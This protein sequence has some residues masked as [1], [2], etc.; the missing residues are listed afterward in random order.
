MKRVL[1]SA[2]LSAVAFGAHAVSINEIRIDQPSTDKNEYIELV[3][4]P[5][6]SLSGL[7]YLVIGDSKDNKDKGGIIEAVVDLN[8]QLLDENGLLLVAESTF[9]PND[10]V[11]YTTELEFENGDSVTHLLVRDFTGQ[12]GLDIDTNNDG[13]IDTP[14]WSSIV[15]SVALKAPESKDKSITYGNVSVGPDRQYVPG[16]VF[17]CNNQWKIGQFAPFGATDTA[18]AANTCTPSNGDNTPLSVSIPQI[19]SEATT[20]PYAGKWV[21]TRG[22]VVANFQ[23][24]NQLKGYFL[25]DLNGDNNPK[26]SDGLFVFAPNGTSVSVGDELEITAKVKEYKGQTQLSSVRKVT[27]I[28]QSN[29]IL[30]VPLTLPETTEGE[31]ERYEGMLVTINEPMTIA[32]NYFLGRYGQMTLASKNDNGELTRIVQPTDAFAANTPEARKLADEN[33][34]RTLILDDGQD[35]NSRG[36]NPSPVP[37]LGLPANVIRGGDQVSNLVGV[38]DFG[39]VDSAPNGKE[40]RDYRLHPTKTPVFTPVN[41]RTQPDAVNG[42]LKIASF[43]VLNYFTTIDNRQPICGPKKD[44][45]CR[46]AD[47]DTELVRQQT[48]IV[49][50]LSAINADVIGLIEIENN[51]ADGALQNLVDALNAEM[52]S[53]TYAG[54]APASNTLGSD[55]ITVALIYKP[56][57]VTPVNAAQTLATGAFD[58]NLESGQSR[59]PLA[60]SFKENATGEVFTAVVNH[61]KSKRPPRSPLNNGNDDQGDGQGS[62]NLRRTEAANEL[63]AWL[64]TKPTGVDDADVIILGDLNAYANEDPIL[65]LKNKGYTDLGKQFDN[66]AYSYTFGGAVGTLDYAL[67]SQTLTP[68]IAGTSIWHINTDEPAVLD[69]D[70]RYNPAGYYSP[71]A[72][73]ASDHDP[74]IVGLNLSSAKPN[75]LD[76]D[77]VENLDDFCPNTVLGAAVNQAGCSDAQIEDNIKTYTQLWPTWLQNMARTFA[78]YGLLFE[79]FIDFSQAQTLL[80]QK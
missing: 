56:S 18:G 10:K 69:Y 62:W 77:G 25:Q 16:H 72:F 31:L 42:R 11:G 7:S 79:G 14:Y 5:N 78:I 58:P 22:V 26:T 2:S 37:Y 59:Q 73:R 53:N 68:Q 60:Q 1:L 4:S 44:Q 38:I 35:V 40:K 34:R 6:E 51:G 8:Q 19:Q 67:S 29:T 17:R 70:E 13:V 21:K 24:N 63:S 66:K 43:N 28:S 3:G 65:A 45:G 23:A 15:D 80:N 30:P 12:K 61:L 41:L 71:D 9:Q 50:A 39:R 32:Q 20:S 64:D 57:V 76:A 55:V 75:D 36:D 47:S 27:V 46:G 33:A 48:K 54:I 49:R 74:V 52:G